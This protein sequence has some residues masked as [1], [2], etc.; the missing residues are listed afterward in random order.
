ML[1]QGRCF[2]GV[3]TRKGSASMSACRVMAWGRGKQYRLRGLV[4][5]R[6]SGR[7]W[8]KRNG[9]EAGWF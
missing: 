6:K 2:V 9:G 3:G 4:G 7:C 1:G 8:E 5:H